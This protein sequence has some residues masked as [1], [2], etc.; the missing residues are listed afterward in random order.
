[1]ME[2]SVDTSVT[3]ALE[4]AQVYGNPAVKTHQ[5]LIQRCYSKQMSQKFSIRL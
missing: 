1:M 4:F 5:W 2:S 3:Y